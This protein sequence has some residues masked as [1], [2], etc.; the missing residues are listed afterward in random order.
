MVRNPGMLPGLMLA[1]LLTVQA[2]AHHEIKRLFETYDMV[3][4]SAMLIL[5]EAVYA[6]FLWRLP[7][8][9]AIITAPVLPERDWASLTL[10]GC[11]TYIA[12]V[13]HD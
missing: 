9:R 12:K 10:Q 3:P 8:L 7:R 2:M 11:S 6:E 13:A 5:P 1:S 4:R